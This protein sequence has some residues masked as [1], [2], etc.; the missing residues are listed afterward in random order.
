M[1]SVP[2]NDLHPRF[3]ANPDGYRAAVERVFARGWYILGPEVEAFE[4]EFA[5][6][7]GINHAIGVANGTDAIELALRAAGIGTGDEVITV[8]HTAVATACG[9][10]QRRKPVFV[11]IRPDDYDR[12][13]C[14]SAAVTPPAVVAVHLRP[15]GSA[16]ERGLDRRLGLLIEDCLGSRRSRGHVAGTQ[17]SRPSALSDQESRRQRWR[18]RDETPLSPS[19]FARCELRLNRSLS[20]R[21]AGGGKPARRKAGD[22]VGATGCGHHE[23]QRL[24]DRY[25]SVAC[26]GGTVPS[27]G[28]IA[29]PPVRRPPSGSRLDQRNS[30]AVASGRGPAIP[31][32]AAG[33]TLAVER[34]SCWKP[35]ERLARL[36]RCR[37]SRG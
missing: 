21:D 12:T 31:V 36:C 13:T 2:F 29:P 3:A 19:V 33:H 18:N 27:P 30:A 6:Y 14:N 4:A 35:S 32:R 24:A 1:A 23:R 7:L 9:I 17:I 11:D 37:C 16:K 26:A 22:S 25:L 8:A 15:A 5:E 10:E 34:G 28:T 20:L